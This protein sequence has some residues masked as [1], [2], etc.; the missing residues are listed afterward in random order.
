MHVVRSSHL[1]EEK[2]KAAD[3]PDEF[4]AGNRNCF[5]CKNFVI[6]LGKLHRFKT[7]KCFARCKK[8]LLVVEDCRGPTYGGFIYEPTYRINPVRLTALNKGWRDRDWNF[9]NQCTEFISMKEEEEDG[10]TKP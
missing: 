1:K 8:N 10:R 2:I 7:E 9:A 5:D 6:S 4:K 3:F